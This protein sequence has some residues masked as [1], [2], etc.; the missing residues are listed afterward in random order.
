MNRLCHAKKKTC[1]NCGKL[2]HFARNA[3][4]RN[5]QTAKTFAIPRKDV[6]PVKADEEND[7][8][9]DSNSFAYTKQKR[10]KTSISPNGQRMQMTIDTGSSINVID[11]NT[12]QKL[13]NIQL[14][15]TSVN[16]YP[17]NS[18]TPVK[19][20]GKFQVLAESK[21]AYTCYNLC[22]VVVVYLAL[23]IE[24]GYVSLRLNHV[25]TKQYRN[26]R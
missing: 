18:K 15:S 25:N 21:Q 8:S 6:R 1:A 2:N 22:E 10:P 13:G 19:M 24:L 23:K 5:T 26:F 17:L 3:E 7:N 11:K 12:L 20:E 16:A 14:Q 4:C 9:S